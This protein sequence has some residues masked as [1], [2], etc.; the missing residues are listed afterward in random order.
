MSALLLALCVG[1]SGTGNALSE[2]DLS[3]ATYAVSESIQRI[4]LNYF[5]PYRAISFIRQESSYEA[6]FVLRAQ[7]WDS[8]K[9]LVRGRDWERRVVSAVYETTM[10]RQMAIEGRE[11]LF[12]PRT[13]VMMEVVY[14]DAQSERTRMWRLK[15]EPPKRLS[16]LTLARKSGGYVYSSKDTIIANLEIYA[17][18]EMVRSAES[19]FVKVAQ[20]RQVFYTDTLNLS[21]EDPG[22]RRIELAV[23][24]GR[25]EDGSYELEV[26]VKTGKRNALVMR[27]H[28]FEV[29][30]SFFRS[31]RTFRE[32]VNQLL[33]IATREEMERLRKAP[34]AERESLWNAFWKSKDETPTTADNLTEEE[35]FR[36]I[37]YCEKHFRHGDNGYRSDRGQVYVMLGPADNVQSLPFESDINAYEVWYYYGANLKL[38]FLDERGFG[39]YKLIEPAGFLERLKK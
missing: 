16:D 7:C 29:I 3:C 14:Q 23:P 20:G 38:V 11:S 4:E 17:D 30:S 9:T 8:R 33:Y 15:I 31:D 19:L 6:R 1:A 21:D 18:A 12:V 25:L 37:A 13:P 24:L 36:R 5:I 10:S 2:V 34:A 39:E 35:Y 26:G 32:K 28:K 27:R 22:H